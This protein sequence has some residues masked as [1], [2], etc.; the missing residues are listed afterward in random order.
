MK[1]Y[2]EIKKEYEHCLLFFRLG[3]FYEMF[4]ED[5]MI[6][7][8]ELDI[9]LTGKA[10]GQEERA[11]MCGVP[12][13]SVD[14]YIAKLIKGGFK[15]AICEQTGEVKDGLVERKVVR[16]ITSGTVSD[17]TILTESKHNY[18]M[19]IYSC[20]MK[21]GTAY[22]IA[23]C[24]V[25]TGIFITTEFQQEEASLK[26]MDE[27][28]RL[29]PA[30]IICNGDFEFDELAKKIQEKDYYYLNFIDQ[31]L[32]EYD[33]A[34]QTIQ[35]HF[36]I[37]SLEGFGLEEKEIATGSAGGL[38]W[39][40]LETQ[41]NDL[42]SISNISYYSISEFMIL[43][44]SSRRNLEL[45]ETIM[46][47]NKKC[48]LFYV[49]N[50]TKTP[51]GTRLLRKWLQQP[52]LDL[53]EIQRRLDSVE[54]LK[55][56]LFFRE[57]LKDVLSNVK[58][59]E[60]LIT[61]IVNK[62][63][64]ARDLFNFKV[65]IEKL[66]EMKLILKQAKTPYL[67][68]LQLHLNELEEIYF[69]LDSALMEEDLPVSIREGGMIA[70]DFNSDLELYRKAK[71]EGTTWI[72]D[73]EKKE[74]EQ[75]GIKNLR[76]KKNR[77]LGYFIEILKSNLEDIPEHYMRKQ[78]CSN[79]ERYITVELRE[80]EE[81]IEGA[82]EQ[83][84]ELEYQLFI[85][86]I[87]A[88][89]KEILKIQ[90]TANVVAVVDALCSLA[91][92][93]DLMNYVKPV[94]EDTNVLEIIDGRHP[95]V[96]VMRRG[97]FIA[98]SGYLDTEDDQLIILTGPNM[99]GKSTY[100][101]QTALI[102]LMAQM[103]GF[104]PAQKARIGV[105]DR[106]FTRVGASD[107]LSAGQSTFMIEMAEV[108]NILNYATS[109]SLL[110]LDEIGRGTSTYDGLSIAQAVLEY[111]VDKNQIGARTLFAT[112]YHELSQLEQQLAGVKN[113]HIAV[114]EEAEQIV[115][116]RKIKKGTIQHSY[117]IEVAKLAGVPK[118]V[119]E[120][121]KEILNQLEDQEEKIILETTKEVP[122]EDSA[123]AYEKEEVYQ[124]LMKKIVNIDTMNLTPMQSMQVLYELQ[125]Q[126]NILLSQ[127]EK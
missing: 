121:S 108:S 106:I 11:P 12:A 90:Q 13:H 107:D 37:S 92:V 73:M 80:L 87:E 111:I 59:M 39:Y 45:T 56:D 35:S 83:I 110:I 61:K 125:E 123:P 113:Y 118:K 96:E 98:N 109:K 62:R 4:F 115:F 20:E 85:E 10:W 99:A 69:L 95:V 52:L 22:G 122:K 72:S 31:R 19:S 64:N 30:E 68:E 101:R 91:E 1:Q 32:F 8:K 18:I 127:K 23:F 116:L 57:E 89:G 34:K 48:S 26:V 74:Q 21:K 79:S 38:L 47:E 97:D 94:V 14:T 50:Y 33:T 102:V 82:N 36:L 84:E 63:A 6:A 120:R 65:S 7:S 28:V 24:D 53:Y 126:V 66:P 71:M 76:I 42:P 119:I 49:I 41:K 43:D 103:G 114:K 100:M 88:V 78:T 46:T 105:V 60:R 81:V 2:L 75:T 77:V 17:D 93:A 112:H 104:V 117:G 3:D 54:E 5:A 55:E 29:E 44:S 67:E 124:N 25:T 70:S 86:L 15:V 58:D 9:T 51:M 16:V 27:I 40:L